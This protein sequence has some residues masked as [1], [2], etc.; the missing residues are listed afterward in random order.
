MVEKRPPPQATPLEWLLLTTIQVASAKQALKC[1]RWYCRRWRIE[2]WHRVMKSGCNVEEHQNHSAAALLRA[3]ALDAIIAW[4]IMLLAILGREP[5]EAPCELVFDPI[6]CEVLAI[7][8]QKK[9]PT[10]GEAVITIAKEGGYLNRKRDRHPGYE[11]LWKGYIQF[12][13]MVRGFG[14]ARKR[15]RAPDD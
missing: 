14:L 2:E 1:L 4:R 6:E 5:P 15:G 13:A 11:T 7:L 9:K 8:T 12:C 10:L 3:I